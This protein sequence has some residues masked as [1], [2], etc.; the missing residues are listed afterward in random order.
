MSRAAWVRVGVLVLL[1]LAGAWLVRATEWVEQE[2]D[3]PARGEAARN[4]FFAFEQ[5]M[6]RL[7]VPLERR[8]ALDALPPA[9][10]VLVL[11]SQY[12][13]LF[14]QRAVQLREWVESGGHLVLPGTMADDAALEKWLPVRLARQPAA[15]ATV[16]PR[17]RPAPQR[18]A[19]REPQCR[20]L[21]A[22]GSAVPA[23]T[24]ERPYEVCAGPFWRDL[25]PADGVVPQWM[26]AGMDRIEVLRVPHGQG[27]VTVHGA[28]NLLHNR[29]LLR[30]DTAPAV[31]A[32]F[33]LHRGTR[34]W[35][36]TEES[37]PPLLLW[38][39]REAAVAVMLATAALLAW[40]WRG[41]VRFGPL[42]VVPIPERRSMR[43]QLVGTAAF[44][45]RHGAAT[46]HKAQVRALHEAACARLPARASL[47]QDE[48]IEAVARA[49][50]LAAVGL[51]HAWRDGPRT[52]HALAGDL[53]LLE[54]A[55]RRL[56]RADPFLRSSTANDHQA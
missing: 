56:L 49:T 2:V 21:T 11:Q 50:G 39:W 36:V 24:V 7:G 14:P 42:G 38:I 31:A 16:P 52:P 30:A 10:A 23:G 35:L 17:E 55:R 41:A 6:Q 27:S 37:R 4:D 45:C 26:L 33:Q 51:E 29:E 43:E 47:G 32:A 5:L 44:L 34:V 28:W 40:L 9:G 13:D 46:L 19:A 48:R 8:R 3:Q 15:Q 53:G 1:V 25:R 20:P 54:E 12:W 18:S 22:S